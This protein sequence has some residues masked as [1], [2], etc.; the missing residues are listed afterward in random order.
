[1]RQL[2]STTRE[3]I[4]HP[5]PADAILPQESVAQEAILTERIIEDRSADMPIADIAVQAEDAPAVSE[6]IQPEA[7]PSAPDAQERTIESRIGGSW[8]VW[9]GGLTLALGGLFLVKYSIE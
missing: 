4:P 3:A 1:L 7:F 8:A 9:L 2:S 5:T 6:Q